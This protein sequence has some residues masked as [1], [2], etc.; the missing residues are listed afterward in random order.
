[1]IET[2][3]TVDAE[4]FSLV[5]DTKVKLLGKTYHH[6]ETTDMTEVYNMFISQMVK[7]GWLEDCD[8]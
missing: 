6:T 7:D 1:M 5:T 4:A 2:T 8:G 3:T